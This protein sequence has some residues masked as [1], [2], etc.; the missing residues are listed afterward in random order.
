M[1]HGVVGGGDVAPPENRQRLLKEP[2]SVA[3]A[4]GVAVA[5]PEN[6]QRLL[7][8]RYFDALRALN[9]VAPPENRQRLLKDLLEAKLAAIAES[10]PTRESPEI[11]ERFTSRA[12]VV[13][14]NQ[15]PHQ[16][17]ARDY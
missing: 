1:R 13:V 7:K 9:G 2:N 11:T 15:L 6:R 17:I 14:V 12:G 8:V 3:A 16:R 4:S 10:C 5:P